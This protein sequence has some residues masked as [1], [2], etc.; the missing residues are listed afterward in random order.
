[1]E[2]KSSR[3]SGMNLGQNEN[4][5]LIALARQNQAVLAV[6]E[7]VRLLLVTQNLPRL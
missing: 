7:A 3:T 2:V 4:E 1:M 5:R 6:A